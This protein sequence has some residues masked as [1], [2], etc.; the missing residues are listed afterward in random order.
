[1]TAGSFLVQAGL[2]SCSL[3]QGTFGPQG[4]IV[5]LIARFR[6]HLQAKVL[7]CAVSVFIRMLIRHFRV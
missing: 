2:A 5:I 6:V 1:M 4:T 7:P 3:L